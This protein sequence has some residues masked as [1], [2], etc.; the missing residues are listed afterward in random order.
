MPRPKKSPRM[1]FQISIAAP[2][3]RKLRRFATARDAELSS[4]VSEALSAYFRAP[5][6][7][8]DL[9]REVKALPSFP[10]LMKETK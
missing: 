5:V 10:L 6:S 8:H 2:L 4:V 7:V 1:R 9:M 3:G